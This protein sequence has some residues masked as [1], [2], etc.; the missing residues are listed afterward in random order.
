MELIGEIDNVKEGGN[1][2][3][4]SPA[5][6]TS[7]EQGKKE[8]IEEPFTQSVEQVTTSANKEKQALASEPK[9]VEKLYEKRG[10]EDHDTKEDKGSGGEG[11]EKDGEITGLGLI[12]YNKE[13]PKCWTYSSTFKTSLR[14]VFVV[15]DRDGDG[16]INH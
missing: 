9:C 8:I 3:S 6:E 14:R 2:S 16:K 1:Q 12:M 11:K 13:S 4:K 7:T 15:F 10:E 5:D